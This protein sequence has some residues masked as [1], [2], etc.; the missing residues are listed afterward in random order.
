MKKS[1]FRF[2]KNKWFWIILVIVLIIVGYLYAKTRPKAA[3]FQYSTAAIGNVVEQV[4][5]TGTVS[6]VGKA[7][8]AFEKSGVIS[9][10]YVKVGDR[11]ST[12]DPIA[13]LDSAT[14]Q[15]ALDS[16]EATLADMS[17]GLTP[18]QYAADQAT[19][20]TASTT[21]ANAL[22]DAVN[23]VHNG[24]VLARSAVADYSDNFFTNPQTANPT[25]N[26]RTDSS[27]TALAMNNERLQI[28]TVLD[29]W[30]N[31]MA[32]A[33]TT[34]ASVL[35]SRAQ[36]YLSTI[37]SFLSDL[38]NIINALSPGNSGLSQTMINNDV[39]TMNTALSTLNQSISAV[40][41]ADTELKSA[42]SGLSQAQNTFALQQSGSTPNSV[43]SQAAKV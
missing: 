4:S 3:S 25:I 10:I 24:Y 21:Y 19:V 43:A 15:A 30:Q 12:G 23:A 39:S 9:H 6:P 7:A 36:G 34:G 26:V 11:V 13:S 35:V 42:A 22:L 16:A 20:T 5:V 1:R 40:S 32:S 28:S 27:A 2:L 38:S 41:G 37:K 31:D 29:N 33:S 18:E 17:S 8:L 14:D